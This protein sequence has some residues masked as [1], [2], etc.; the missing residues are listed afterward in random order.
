M[1]TFLVVFEAS[2]G[3]QTILIEL[4]ENEMTIKSGLEQVVF[5]S[6]SQVVNRIEVVLELPRKHNADK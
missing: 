3:V 5:A 4:N 2:I 1:N 6:E